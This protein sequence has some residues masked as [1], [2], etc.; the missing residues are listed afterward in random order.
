MIKHSSGILI[1]TILLYTCVGLSLAN[2]QALNLPEAA[3]FPE[4][5][6]PHDMIIGDPK[7]YGTQLAN[8]DIAKGDVR[9]YLY[10]LRYDTPQDEVQQAFPD[11]KITLDTRG[12]EIGGD[13]YDRDMAYNDTVDAWLTQHY[14]QSVSDVMQV[15]AARAGSDTDNPDYTPSVTAIKTIT[16]IRVKADATY[17]MDIAHTWRID[18][19]KGVTSFGEQSIAYSADKE[20]IDILEATITQPDGTVIRVGADAIHDQSEAVSDGAAS[21]SDTRYKVI[22]YPQVQVGSLL[23]YKLRIRRHTP[24]IPGHFTFYDFYSPH[25]RYANEQISLTVSNKLP[26][27]VAHQGGQLTTLPEQNGYR[28]YQFSYQQAHA[29][30]SETMEVDIEDHAPYFMASSFADYIAMGQAYQQRAKPM[31]AVTPAIQR[32]AD[33]ITAGITDERAQVRALYH[34]VSSNI[35]YVFIGLGDG[36]LV[37]QPADMV[38][39]NRYGDC[40][41][42]TVLLEALLAAKGIASSPVLIN[43]G[44]AYQLAEV[45]VLHPFNHVITYVPSLD[46]YLDSTAQ[47]TPFG[48]L[49]VYVMDKPV[50]ITALNKLGRTPILTADD[51][52]MKSEVRMRLNDDGSVI[53]V[54]QTTSTGWVEDDERQTHFDW[55]TQRHRMIKTRL[56]SY[57]EIGDGDIQNVDPQDFS[58]PFVERT[59]FKLEPMANLPGPAA[60]TMP[61]G[62]LPFSLGDYVLKKPEVELNIPRY[63]VN[64]TI[65]QRHTLTLPDGVKVLYLPKDLRF[66]NTLTEYAASY[67][68]QGQDIHVSRRMQVNVPDFVCEQAD[69]AQLAE[70]MDVIRRDLRGQIIYE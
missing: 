36:G 29:R 63:C 41:G 46:L 58:Q 4:E 11:I 24:I 60:I 48:A 21:F 3:L 30:P 12:C 38:L 59:R 65:E 44:T 28:R 42:H 62:P 52:A 68:H 33:E 50:V 17:T 53:G 22:V 40:K 1:L 6:N 13:E 20:T 25:F 9:Y 43:S 5:V 51:H 10:G 70:L 67:E 27:K 8:E 55:M 16:Q 34:W 23:H 7:T 19:E 64:R 15:N 49:P 37:P 18:T 66:Q 47:M 57:R 31:A 69:Q 2:W 61:T 45:A 26:L 14:G 39:K 54:S 35:R 32:M 56:E